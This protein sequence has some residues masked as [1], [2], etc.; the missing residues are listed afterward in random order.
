[1]TDQDFLDFLSALGQEFC[2]ALSPPI[3]EEDIVPQDVYEV[4]LR[5]FGLAPSPEKLAS[6]SESQLE[7]LRSECVRYFECP[8][9]TAQHVGLAVARTLARWPTHC[10]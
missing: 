6:L 4:W 2:T 5:V 1:M 7:Q 3:P 8:E 10:T 9:V